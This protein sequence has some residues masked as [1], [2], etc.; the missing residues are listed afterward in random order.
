[1]KGIE[2][3]SKRTVL[4]VYNFR[5]LYEI[6]QSRFAY[7]LVDTS[8]SKDLLKKLINEIYAKISDSG[9]DPFDENVWGCINEQGEMN[10]HSFAINCDET[11]EKYNYDYTID[12]I[13]VFRTHGEP[14]HIGSLQ[15]FPGKV[16]RYESIDLSSFVDKYIQINE[17]VLID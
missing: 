3:I 8:E 5:T 9:Y 11:V 1:M 16:L 6:I 4:S 15:H 10:V 14:Y 12:V 17:P 13:V 2:L 7:E